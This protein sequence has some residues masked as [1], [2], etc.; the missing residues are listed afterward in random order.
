MNDKHS[1]WQ[2]LKPAI[3]R[4]AAC[5]T[6]ALTALIALLLTGANAVQVNGRSQTLADDRPNILFAISDDQSWAHTG[7]NGDRA[8]KTPTFDRVARE[9]VLFPNS[10]CSSPSC[11]PSRAAVLTGQAFSRLEE[12]ANLLSTL[13]K[14][15]AVY[16]DLLEAAGYHVGYTRKGWDP[17]QYAP[18]GRTRNP[19]GPEFKS[20]AEFMKNVPEGRPFC[21]WFGGR[22]PHRP[23]EKG[24]GVASGIKLADIRVPPF[25]PDTPEIR[26]DLADYLFEIERFDHDLREM[27]ALLEKAGKLRNT[28]VVITSDNGMPFPRAKTNLYD[29]GTRM[30]LAI[31]WP[32]RVPGGRVITDF[33]SHTDFAPTFLEAAGL[34]PPSEMTGRSLLPILTGTKSGRVEPQRDKAFTGR[35]RHDTF[36]D[37]LG[38]PMRAVRTEKFLYIRNFKP[39]RV[40][41][42]DD[43]NQNQ[44]NDRGPTKTFLVENKNNPAIQP[45]YQM[46]YGKRPTEELYDLSVDAGQVNNVAGRAKYATEL[47]KLRAELDDWMKKLKDPRSLPGDKGDIFDRYPVYQKKRP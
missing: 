20:F 15:F 13:P 33:I 6:L 18:G 5:T 32:A 9:G 42:G 40:P 10:F 2:R 17:G 16:P 21:F 1:L 29:W 19:A 14:K 35:E 37:N 30:P 45:F 41:A 27:L 7:A 26:S 24:S 12:G 3:R 8:V 25:L 43:P 39:E 31:Q 46:A 38:Y 11:T 4:R 44:D 34:K 36:R 22:D 28:I 23:Y 47:K